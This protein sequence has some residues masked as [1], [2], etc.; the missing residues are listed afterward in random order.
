MIRHD[1]VRLACRDRLT[2]LSVA[3]TGTTTLAATTA[4]YTRSAGSFLDDGFAVGME[5]TPTGFPQTATG[6]ITGL[7]ATLME[8]KDG[9]T[10]ASAAGSR[11]LAALLPTMRGWENVRVSPVP[12]VPYVTEQYLPGEARKRGLGER[13]FL[14]V[15]ALYVV[16]CWGPVGTDATALARLADAIVAR[17][18]ATLPL[19][20]ATGDT[21]VVRSDVAPNAS[22][23]TV[24]DPWAVCTVR[25]PVRL[26][27]ANPR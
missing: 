23:L 26:I 15:T 16:Q 20:L 1:L 3:T 6:V 24:L 8:I 4:G 27:T 2:G 14:E 9:R 7:T 22:A 10:A 13:G 21:A 12:G 5:V 25:I 11:S 17:F 18:P 19:A